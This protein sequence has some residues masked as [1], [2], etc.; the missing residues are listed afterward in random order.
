MKRSRAVKLSLIAVLSPWLA[1]CNSTE[2][3]HADCVIK[4][5]N[6]EWVKVDDNYCEGH[7]GTH[8]S[9]VYIYNGTTYNGRVTGGTTVRPRGMQITTGSGKVIQRGGFGGKSS[10]GS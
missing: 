7:P 3:V 4:A 6:G 10:G 1:A 8:S 9:Y 5:E 2:E